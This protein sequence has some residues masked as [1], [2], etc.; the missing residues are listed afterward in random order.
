MAPA[1]NDALDAAWTAVLALPDDDPAFDSQRPGQR[2]AAHDLGVRVQDRLLRAL[3]RL[4]EGMA[5]DG[6]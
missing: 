2:R 1:L 6:V 5:S 4:A 3:A